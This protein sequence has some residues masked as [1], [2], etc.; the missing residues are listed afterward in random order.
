MIKKIM[1]L[2]MFMAALSFTSCIN[3]ED[4]I[5]NNPEGVV[6]TGKGNVEI[7]LLVPN[8]TNGTRVSAETSDVTE[9]GTEDE[10]RILNAKIYLFNAKSGNFYKCIEP[11]VQ[12]I[13]SPEVVGQNVS[14][15]K[16]SYRLKAGAYKVFVVANADYTL[17][18]ATIDELLSYVD[19]NTYNK[20]NININRNNGVLM[21]NRG[22]SAPEITI[23]ED[24]TTEVS[25]MLERVLAKIAIMKTQTSWELK[26]EK[27]STYATITPSNYN[28][29]NLS[30]EFYLFR[31]VAVLPMAA[32]T[33]NVPDWRMPEN[34][35]TIPDANG[36]AIDPYF[37]EKTVAGAATFDG[38]RIFN[39]PLAKSADSDF[40]Y[41]GTFNT[42]GIYA[43]V[44]CTGNT[45]FCPAQLQTYTTGVQVAANMTIPTS[46]CFNADGSNIDMESTSAPS[47]LYY[48]NYNFYRNLEAVNIVGKATIPVDPN[49]SD[50]DLWKDYQIKRFETHQ[51]SFKCF[52]NTWI[53]HLDNANPTKL[54]VMEYA[55]VRNNIYKM[56]IND[57][58]GLG[59]G[60]PNVDPTPVEHDGYLDVDFGVMPWIV[61]SQDTPLGE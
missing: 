21:T 4:V 52:Y 31:H 16:I 13:G 60:T 35:G 47:E 26:D 29:V 8:Q 30:K 57:V 32:D 50:A 59:D 28:I 55:I 33:P 51:G 38:S 19:K 39:N 44:Y 15:K 7:N 24:K 56:N 22:A 5:D 43:T 46:H 45:N 40:S 6:E 58:V 2:M 25:I 49:I 10:Y 42:A 61:R 34:F 20:T 27:G 54:G 1:S 12:E 23:Y 3:D 9:L 37:F 14:Y 36:Y 17:A 41:P 11:Q 18:P 48:F 53:K